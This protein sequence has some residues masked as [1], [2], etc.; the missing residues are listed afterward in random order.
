MVIDPHAGF[1]SGVKRVINLAERK[2]EN[3]QN[4]ASL[5]ELI[6]NRSESN[7]LNKKGLKI[8]DHSI[9]D[10]QADSKNQS[11][12][13]IRAHGEPPTTFQKAKENGYQLIDGTCPVVHRSQKIA[14]EYHQKGYTI[15]IVGKPNHPEVIGIGGYCDGNYQVLLNEKDIKDLNPDKKYF[16]LAQT[17]I[18]EVRFQKIVKLLK[19]RGFKVTVKNTICGFISGRERQMREFAKEL[20]VVIMVGGKHSSNTRVLF[21]I[22]KEFNERSYWIEEAAEFNPT[23]VQNQDRVGITGSASTPHWLMDKVKKHVEKI[24]D[25][26]CA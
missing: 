3:Q 18:S 2:L 15:L 20:D 26:V 19:N 23:W 8:T 13:L 9:L 17:T 14:Q 22:C 21:N 11:A 6:H 24:F 1:C 5:G 4:L 25:K 16:V 12:L 10:K 7:R